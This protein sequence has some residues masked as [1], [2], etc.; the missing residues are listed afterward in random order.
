MTTILKGSILPQTKPYELSNRAK[1][2]QTQ[3]IG[4]GVVILNPLAR[5][6]WVQKPPYIPGGSLQSAVNAGK[7]P[8][9]RN[10]RASGTRF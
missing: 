10:L 1:D 6:S 5:Y 9:R 4:T 2:L 3:Q 8:M 7:T